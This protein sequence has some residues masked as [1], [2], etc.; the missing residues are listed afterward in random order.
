MFLYLLLET[1][2]VAVRVSA[3]LHDEGPPTTQV[4]GKESA[5]VGRE[6]VAIALVEGEAPTPAVARAQVASAAGVN[7]ESDSQS[8]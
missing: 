4:S 8:C 1:Q 2:G 6:A 3:E 5:P 7:G